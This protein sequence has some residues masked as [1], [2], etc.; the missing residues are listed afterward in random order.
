MEIRNYKFEKVLNF[1]YLGT[2]VDDKNEKSVEI[3]QRIQAGHKAYFKY[4]MYMKSKRISK[5]TKM[6]IYK[7]AIRPVA[8]YAAETMCLTS[9]DEEK[10][11]IFERKIIRKIHGPKK[12]GEDEYRRLMNC[13]IKEIL[14]GEDIVKIIKAQRIRWYG[15]ISRREESSTLR[16]I[17]NWKPSGN[18]A[19]GRPKIRWED[20]VIN[21][22]KSM[23]VIGWRRQMQNRKSWKKVVEDAKTHNNL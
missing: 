21:D 22:I 15:H 4:K 6:K 23:G 17:T 10:L 3:N 1:K 11:R 16:K 20:Q 9:R 13:E 19:R 8:T 2:I 14:K 7:A 5:N 12:I 18:R